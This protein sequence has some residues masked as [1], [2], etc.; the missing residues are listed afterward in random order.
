MAQGQ[1]SRARD[2]GIV[3]GTLAPG[4]LNAITDVADVAVG[5]ATLS[6]AQ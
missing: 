5:Q 6:P 1:R 4:R 3:V 2:L